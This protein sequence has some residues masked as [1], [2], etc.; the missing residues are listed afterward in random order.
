MQLHTR[1]G[2][3]HK[4]SRRSV[5]NSI[6][7]AAHLI[8]SRPWLHT[9]HLTVVE[10]TLFVSLAASVTLALG[11]EDKRAGKMILW[12]KPR[13]DYNCRRIP[14][15]DSKHQCQVVPRT[16]QRKGFPNQADPE[17]LCLTC[18]LPESRLS[19]VTAK[20]DGHCE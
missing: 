2:T 8:Q 1:Q 19:Y 7:G 15:G 12:A 9:A 5:K 6:S 13:F 17:A 18:S 4:G 14:Q 3:P 20:K 11:Q 16:H 10:T